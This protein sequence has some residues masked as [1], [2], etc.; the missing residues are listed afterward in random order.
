MPLIEVVP[1][2]RTSL[3]AAQRAMALASVEVK[4]SVREISHSLR[5]VKEPQ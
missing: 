1:G 4:W 5:K 2:E 3:E